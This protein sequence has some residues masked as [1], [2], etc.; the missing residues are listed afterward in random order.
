MATPEND[1]VVNQTE[2][3]QEVVSTTLDNKKVDSKEVKKQEKANKKDKKSKKQPKEHK[4]SK[5]K[6]TISELKKVS[7]PSFGKV[8]KQTLVVIG[9]VIF[10]TLVLFAIDKL[11]DLAYQPLFKWITRQ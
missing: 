1:V 10:F 6:E 5:A 7:W 8:V 9:M 3:N 2:N 11:L 4:V